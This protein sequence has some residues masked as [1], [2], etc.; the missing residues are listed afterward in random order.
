MHIIPRNT[1][2][3]F[4]IDINFE[5]MLFEIFNILLRPLATECKSVN[6]S[7]VFSMATGMFFLEAEQ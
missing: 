2:F 5:K 7:P 1:C 4:L 3:I 6:N